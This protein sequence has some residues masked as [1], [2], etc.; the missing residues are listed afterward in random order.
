M[1]CNL[2]D[3]HKTLP[4]GH[5]MIHQWAEDKENEIQSTCIQ[6]MRKNLLSFLTN[7]T[8]LN[9]HYQQVIC[10]GQFGHAIITCT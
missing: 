5:L 1:E 10:D 3:R 4:L 6:Q 2:T 9:V 7:P 8:P